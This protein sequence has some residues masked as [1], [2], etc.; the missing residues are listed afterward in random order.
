M[1][2]K[3]KNIEK[4]P[5]IFKIILTLI[6]K[7]FIILL[8]ITTE[9]SLIYKPQ[10]VLAESSISINSI[11]E[12]VNEERVENN[13]PP[14]TMNNKLIQAA[15]NKAKYLLNSNSFDHSSTNG[16]KIF[17]DW[18]RETNYE[19]SF[20]GEN[21][22]INFEN[23]ESILKAWLESPSHK[24]NILDEFLETGIAVQ[25]KN[26]KI[27]VVQIFGRSAINPI[28]LDKTI[29]NHISENLLYLDKDGLIK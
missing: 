3:K 12:I 1:N 24:E 20:I 26:S 6:M 14:L 4:F 27:L 16:N 15:N 2:K 19:Y 21:L 28:T 11:F 17:S 29:A 23:N 8:I 9:L 5:R 13:L 22:A 25:S 7:L 10:I 18:I